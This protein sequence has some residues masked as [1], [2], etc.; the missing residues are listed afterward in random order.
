MT[1][2]PKIPEFRRWQN[3]DRRNPDFFDLFEQF[4]FEAIEAGATKLSGWLVANRI[5]WETEIVTR[6]AERKVPNLCIAYFTRLFAAKHPQHVKLFELR[7][8]KEP[9][10]PGAMGAYLT[11]RCAA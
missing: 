3:W 4:T 2:K 11:E 6:G 10:A 9:L 1:E 7:R 8:M 5:R